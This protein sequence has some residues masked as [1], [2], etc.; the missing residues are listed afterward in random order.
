MEKINREWVE[1]KNVQEHK[2]VHHDSTEW[3]DQIAETMSKVKS[4]PSLSYEEKW[5]KNP[6]HISEENR[7][8]LDYEPDYNKGG[9]RFSGLEKA[10][11]NLFVGDGE[12]GGI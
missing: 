3:M 9:E 11:F 10:L 1:N 6:N 7:Y 2:W 8:S 5:N 4:D 12:G